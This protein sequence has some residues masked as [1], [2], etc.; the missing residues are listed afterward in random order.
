MKKILFAAAILLGIGLDQLSKVLV[1][2]SIPMGDTSPVWPNI[3]HFTPSEN[4]G[5]AFSWFG[6]SP[7]IVICISIIAVPILIW[8]V[9]QGWKLAPKA[10]LVSQALLL[11][12]AFG[13]LV[14]RILPPHRVR[15]FLDFRPEIPFVGHWAIFNI[16]D[17]CICVGAGLLLISEFFLVKG[18]Q[19]QEAVEIQGEAQG[20][21]NEA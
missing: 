7:M 2:R 10:L 1:F 16:A 5:V 4:P 11:I 18:D 15:D 6:D 8:W 17:V 14:D 21:G 13:N 3:L 12:G 20:S 19:K 9:W